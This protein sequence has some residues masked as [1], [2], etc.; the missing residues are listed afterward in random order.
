MEAKQTFK[1]DA[2]IRWYRCNI[3]KQ[4]LRGLMQTSDFHG[5][6]QVLCQL[7]LFTLTGAL[8]Y[9]AFLKVDS[10]NW[11]WSVP[12]LYVALF[13]H[14]T[15]GPFMGLVAVHELVH[16][17]PFKTKSFNEFFLRLYSFISWSD[18]LW[19][20]PSHVK[21]HQLTVHS[22]YDGEV[23]LPQT[24]A[25]NDW[26]FW[27]SLF[28]WNPKSTWD[29]IKAH[30]ARAKGDVGGVWNQHILPESNE[31]LR[32]KHRNWARIVLIGHAALA[33][34]FILTGHWFLIVVF[35]IGTH[36]CGWLGLLCGV[37]QHYGMSSDVD[38]FRL[39]CRTF[40]CSWLPGF[41]YWNMQYHVEHHMYPAVPFYNLPKLR[42]ALEHDLPA[43]PHGLRA[44]WKG[45]LE[46]YQKRKSE[47]NYRFIPELPTTSGEHAD[48]KTLERE[49]ALE[50]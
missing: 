8:A 33:A 20:R 2:R 3:D 14:G 32:R 39:C 45:I 48:D 35:T 5:F 40:T 41:Y 29:V 17:T 44:T 24:L 9:M 6:R 31:I 50:L 28:A 38:D 19:F 12:L 23:V 7:G 15:N 21:H 36:Y 13:A 30:Y 4:V 42:H 1:T 22:D 47:P 16:K 49:A 46:V 27:V 10:T 18:Y 11:M 37:P 26:K 34:T 25:F 43:A